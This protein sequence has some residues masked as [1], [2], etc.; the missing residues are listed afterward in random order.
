LHPVWDF[1]LHYI[2]PGREVGPWTYAI[3]CLTFDW[4][5]AAYVFIRYRGATVPA[6]NRAR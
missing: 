6:P 2:G 1:G 4:V 5:V 3:A